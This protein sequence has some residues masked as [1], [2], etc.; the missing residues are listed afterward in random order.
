MHIE[1]VGIIGIV[2]SVNVVERGESS[3][4]E[5]NATSTRIAERIGE[6]AYLHGG[7][8]VGAWKRGLLRDLTKSSGTSFLL[9]AHEAT[10]KS[11]A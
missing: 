11:P 2:G 8:G 3:M 1:P 7:K 5:T 9:L 10:R 4:E 6:R